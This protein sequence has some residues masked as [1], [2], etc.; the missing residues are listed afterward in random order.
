V[1]WPQPS[2]YH[3]AIQAPGIC[4]RDPELRSGRP[5][6]ERNGLPKVI[7]GNFA[8]VYQIA[9]SNSR[10]AVRCFLTYF[11]DQERRYEAISAELERLRLPFMVGFK[12][13]HSGI[14]VRGK[15]YPILR[16]DWV[17]G[18]GLSQYVESNLNNPQRLL[19]LARD[20]VECVELLEQNGLSHGDLQHGNILI[21][22]NGSV[23]LIDYDGMY[24]PALKGWG[25]HELGHASYQHPGRDPHQ[26]FGPHG[27]RFSAWVL[28]LSL[29]ALCLEP[30]LWFDLK[31]GGDRLLFA[32]RDLASPST[33]P[34]FARLEAS[35]FASVR[36]SAQQLRGLLAIPEDGAPAVTS[37]L[38]KGIELPDRPLNIEVGAQAP[39]R[40]ELGDIGAGASW[41]RDHLEPAPGVRFTGPFRAPRFMLGLG[42]GTVVAILAASVVGL[43]AAPFAG[44]V[45]LVIITAVA[46]GLALNLRNRPE[47][48]AR[49]RQKRQFRDADRR[50]KDV[51]SGIDAATR[52]HAQEQVAE[53]AELKILADRLGA[54]GIR[55]DASIARVTNDSQRELNQLRTNLADTDRRQREAL[56]AALERLRL[57]Y[58]EQALRAHSIH[59][60]SVTGIGEALKM[61]LASA[62]LMTAADLHGVRT[63]QVGYGNRSYAKEIAEIKIGSA[64]RHVEGVGPA[65]ARALEDWRRTVERSDPRAPKQLPQA[66]YDSITAQTEAQRRELNRRIA[67]TEQRM[68]QQFAAI[69]QTFASEQRGVEADI[70]RTKA[71]F[72]PK[73]RALDAEVLLRRREL[74]AA[75]WTKG[76][77]DRELK[78]FRA[79]T[80]AGYLAAVLGLAG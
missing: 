54:A 4:F 3:E 66:Q 79:V 20:F 53:L 78:R 24:V 57:A 63:R 61:R 13:E 36:S 44:L 1:T 29:I 69:H 42:V 28:A 11:E 72:A 56:A 37:A 70:A 9:T 74:Q 33:S 5:T 65:K 71:T 48:Q 62:G 55:R 31:A 38:V 45:A 18:T 16:M 47:W 10:F 77:A 32:Q 40:A 26:S 46:V 6:L 59:A 67:D 34:A 17:E 60:A 22:N 49:R 76:G 35:P 43:L 12:F 41:V 68:Q 19:Q 27:D 75:E 8:S 14:L 58:F 73:F 25:S 52:K 51:R 15:W 21:Q 80:I 23:R 30:T 39:G 50:V 64:W 2:D 7:A